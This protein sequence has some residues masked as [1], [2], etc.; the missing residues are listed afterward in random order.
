MDSSTSTKTRGKETTSTRKK[1][2]RPRLGDINTLHGRMAPTLSRGLVGYLPSPRRTAG[3]DPDEPRVCL[4]QLSLAEYEGSLTK[5]PEDLPRYARKTL[6]HA[7][8]PSA[9]EVKLWQE[10][11]S[12]HPPKP[13]V[14]EIDLACSMNV[15]PLKGALK[16]Q[17][18]AQKQRQSPSQAPAIAASA[19]E[20]GP[21]RA[22]QLARRAA[23]IS[24]RP[25]AVKKQLKAD[26]SETQLCS[27]DDNEWSDHSSDR[28]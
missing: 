27:Q 19:A 6:R 20:L 4:S 2:E 13:V 25:T 28:E 9:A 8:L 18:L 16:A 11:A 17:N 15:D 26:P 24:D 3:F 22:R 10:E 23:G 1:R 21:A 12:R 7:Q 14:R 5:Q